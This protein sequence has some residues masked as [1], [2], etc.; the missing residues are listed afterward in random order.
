M[1][2]AVLIKPGDLKI[3]NLELP[4]PG[5]AEVLIEVQLA[6]ICGSDDSIYQGKVAV[7]LPV[8]PGHEA[9][10]R[11]VSLGEGVKDRK[12]GQRVTIQPNFPCEKCSVCQS[13]LRNVCPQK[14]RLGLD[15]NG[16]FGQYV[17]VPSAYTWPVPDSLENEV[18]VFTEPIAVA[19]HALYKTVPE[20][21]HRVLVFGA[22]VI[23]LLMVQLIIQEG[24]EV[25]TYDLAS[26]RLSLSEELGAS[27]GLQ[28]KDDLSD[29]GPFD[30]IY[31][32][33]GAPEALE[34]AIRLASPG[35][36]IVLLGLP[37]VSH[38]ILTTTIVRNEL[39]LFGSM[40][41]TDEFPVVLEL[42]EK[43]LIK[44]RPL[45]SGIFS[46]EELPAALKGF[47]SPKRV[48]TLV[49]ISEDWSAGSRGK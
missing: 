46:L 49:R 1:K 8:V 41:Y 18:A 43:G 6:G 34:Q 36:T 19:Y 47:S 13:G 12:V 31:E 27:A 33:S 26:D 3:Q 45:I 11:I 9:V 39:R 10:G 48:K 30:L 14:V 5:P 24:N 17:K 35:A 37:G 22:G 38:P 40:I 29:Q 32:T 20:P 25:F 16:V 2:C 44:T 7:P 21:G 15:V 4:E 42:L 28:T 23:G